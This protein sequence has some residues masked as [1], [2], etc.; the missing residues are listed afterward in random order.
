MKLRVFPWA[1]GQDERGKLGALQRQIQ[2]RHLRS[3]M[4]GDSGAETAMNVYI[5]VGG[6]DSEGWTGD[7]RQ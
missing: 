5:C 6:S 1:I 7:Q 4:T 2:G 3:G